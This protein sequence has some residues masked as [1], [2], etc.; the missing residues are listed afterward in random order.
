MSAIKMIFDT[1]QRLALAVIREE[2]NL[3]EPDAGQDE[4]A[5]AT[6]TFGSALLRSHCSDAKRQ[7]SALAR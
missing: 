5:I 4:C 3:I 6:F 2:P 1:S 7:R